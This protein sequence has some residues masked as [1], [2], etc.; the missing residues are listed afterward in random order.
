MPSYTNQTTKRGYLTDTTVWSAGRVPQAGD[1]VLV[2]HQLGS[3]TGN[4]LTC[5]QLDIT[6]DGDFGRNDA[7]SYPSSGTLTITCS[8]SL[9]V[10]SQNSLIDAFDLWTGCLVTINAPT[11]TYAGNSSAFVYNQQPGSMVINGNVTISNPGN[12]FWELNSGNST[13]LTINGNVLLTSVGAVGGGQTMAG[14]TAAISITGNLSCDA[15]WNPPGGACVFSLDVGVS[16]NI[17]GNVDFHLAAANYPIDSGVAIFNFFGSPTGGSVPAR[18][19]N[20]TVAIVGSLNLYGYIETT[21][22]LFQ[23]NGLWGSISI[24]GTM[25]P[26]AGGSVF[27]PNPLV[28]PGTSVSYAIA[29]TDIVQGSTPKEIIGPFWTY[30]GVPITSGTPLAANFQLN[31]GGTIT[32]PA[33]TFTALTADAKCTYTFMAA[34]T[35]TL[36]QISLSGTI[37]ASMEWSRV[38][39]VGTDELTS[40]VDRI[41]M[42]GPI[43]SGGTLYV[44]AGDDYPSGVAW[45]FGV[46]SG[47]MSLTGSTPTIDI[48]RIIGG[49]ASPTPILTITGQILTG[50]Y[51]LN[52]V[53]Y[54]TILQFTPTAAQTAKLT[55]WSPNAYVY[56]VRC[57]WGSPT[58]TQTVTVVT[59]SPCTALW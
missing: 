11:V 7:G 33:G 54:S 21:V 41:S 47:F 15:T 56:R 42:G 49:V 44:N 40:I 8:N 51:T 35:S 26:T 22:N 43:D 19:G 50:S 55:Q 27:S 39:Q 28:Q 25:N 2:Q 10:F 16:I 30:A 6:L 13:S 34:E 31:T 20:G 14:F 24:G 4:T 18:S 32:T 17:G 23:A 45:Q 3:H 48:T 36:G 53:T 37:G 58:P 57:I 9:N 38:F 46:P 29:K 5:A 52:G 59:P 1:V 12:G